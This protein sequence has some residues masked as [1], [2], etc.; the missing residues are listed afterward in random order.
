MK[1]HKLIKEIVGLSFLAALMIVLQLTASYLPKLPGNLSLNL[2]LVPL[3]I[4]SILYGYKGGTFLGIVNATVILLDSATS[5]YFAASF[6]GTILVVMLKSIAA[7]IITSFVFRLIYKKSFT[8]AVILASIVCPLIN[9]SIFVIGSSIFF[10]SVFQGGMIVILTAVYLNFFV[11]LAIDII[12]S[13]TILF[14]IKIGKD[15][16]KI[17]E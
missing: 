16:F 11:E 14:V 1:N 5:I 15:Q 3:V 7:G 4:G 10:K 2:T 17:G 8:L 6:F 12:L 13:S 9:T